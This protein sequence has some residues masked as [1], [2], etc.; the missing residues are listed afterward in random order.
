MPAKKRTR[1]WHAIKR[2]LSDE[3]MN[4]CAMFQDA[5]RPD[6]RFA[7]YSD[8]L[9]EC[10]RCAIAD[11]TDSFLTDWSYRHD[12]NRFVFVVRRTLITLS[13]DSCRI[14][15]VLSIPDVKV[16][17][18]GAHIDAIIKTLLDTKS[19]VDELLRAIAKHSQR[20]TP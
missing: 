9:R 17:E 12:I 2:T 4:E 14:D 5:P 13:V 20:T 16:A 19:Q 15:R 18:I 10:V 7:R 11:E 6:P 1:N 8:A 3:L